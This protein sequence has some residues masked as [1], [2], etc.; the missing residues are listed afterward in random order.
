M[1]K[2]E[3]ITMWSVQ[4]PDP[5][6]APSWRPRPSYIKDMTDF[7]NLFNI[8]CILCVGLCVCKF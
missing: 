8:I 7:I 1:V 4:W 6:A 3:V 5:M 2:D